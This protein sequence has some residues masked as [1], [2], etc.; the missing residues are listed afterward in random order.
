MGA[1]LHYNV[2][3]GYVDIPRPAGLQPGQY[4]FKTTQLMDARAGMGTPQAGGYAVTTYPWAGATNGYVIAASA[5]F[6]YCMFNISCKGT[7]AAPADASS[8]Q[9]AKVTPIVTYADCWDEFSWV[10]FV[11]AMNATGTYITKVKGY[12]GSPVGTEYIA[13]YTNPY[14]PDS[15]QQTVGLFGI[16]NYGQYFTGGTAF[17][18]L[19]GLTVGSPPGFFVCPT[20]D[21]VRRR[22]GTATLDTAPFAMPG[23]VG[24]YGFLGGAGQ[25]PTGAVVAT[26]H[27]LSVAPAAGS[28][29]N[30]TAVNRRVYLSGAEYGANVLNVANYAAQ[31]F[32][33]VFPRTF[34][35][36]SC[37]ASTGIHCA[38][39]LNCLI[40]LTLSIVGSD[41]VAVL[42]T[43]A[44][45]LTKPDISPGLDQNFIYFGTKVTQTRMVDH[46]V[47]TAVVGFNTTT[48]L[49]RALTQM[50]CNIVVNIVVNSVGQM[51][52][53]EIKV[54]PN[55]A[56]NNLGQGW[57]DKLFWSTFDAGY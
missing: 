42:V 35:N 45:S 27:I 14:E 36:G 7:P 33:N 39:E 15:T 17:A 28:W 18:S 21:G 3:P 30:D 23:Y 19:V 16:A 4:L 40:S 20:Y 13:D 50:D 24:Q 54:V 11:R 26:G 46:N 53:C 56:V 31:Y 22:I 8:A 47:D 43:D 12:L 5:T 55:I 37:S 48:T 49:T 9:F 32:N 52:T 6:S 41:Y 38:I 10:D 34:Y 44:I 25:K 2:Y 1:E 51:T 57:H 29:V